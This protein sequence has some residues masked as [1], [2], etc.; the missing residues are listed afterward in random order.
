MGRNDDQNQRAF[1][2]LKAVS[3]RFRSSWQNSR[4]QGFSNVRR[5][6]DRKSGPR[7]NVRVDHGGG[8]VRISQE[9]SHCADIV[10]CF[11]EKGGSLME[12]E[13]RFPTVSEDIFEA[14]CDKKGIRCTRIPEKDKKTADYLVS[15]EKLTLVVEVKQI[16]PNAGDKE[17]SK[18][19]GNQNSPGIE[20]PSKRVQKLLEDG[21]PQV[22]GS[23]EGK[24]PTMIALYNNSGP[25]NFV[26]TWTVSKAMFG[27]FGFVCTL[28]PGSSITVSGHGYFGERKLTKN[29]FRHLSIVGVLKKEGSERISL[30]CYH[31]PFATIPVEPSLLKSIAEEQYIHL[32]PHKRGFV[33]WEPKKIT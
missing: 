7:Q 1:S 18:V 30:K 5:G 15:L 26:D 3:I 13:V 12:K 9:F 24:W 25:W 33:P 10:A 27:L 11:K 6:L 29:T 28:K 17:L 32:D 23:S 4:F 14:L 22:K 21:Y 16:D 20:S 31:N 8:A 19:W 2:D